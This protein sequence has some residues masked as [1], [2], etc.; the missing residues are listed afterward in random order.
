MYSW[1]GHTTAPLRWWIHPPESK[2]PAWLHESSMAVMA[3]AWRTSSTSRSPTTSPRNSPS[4]RSAGPTSI[5]SAIPSIRYHRTL[6]VDHCGFSAIP[7]PDM[8][9]S[10]ALLLDLAACTPPTNPATHLPSHPPT[11]PHPTLSPPSTTT[12]HSHH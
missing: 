2:Q 4:V 3:P 5:Q 10:A 9:L 1:Q 12:L 6:G 11:P 7:A 8:R